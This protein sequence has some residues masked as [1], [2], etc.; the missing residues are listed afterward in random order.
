[1]PEARLLSVAAWLLLAGAAPPPLRPVWHTASPGVETSEV[2]VPVAGVPWRTRLVLARVDPARVTLRVV[3]ARRDDGRGAWS[4]DSAPPR[5]LVAF[6]AG[7]FSTYEPWGWIVQ[8]GREL[9]PP[10]SG[11]LA[12]AFVVDTAGTARIVPADSV[13]TVRAAGGV[14]QAVQSYPVLVADGVPPA[15][16]DR[17]DV[18]H[19]DARLALGVLGD[20]RV[21]VVLTRFEGLGESLDGVPLGPTVPEMAALMRELGCRAAMLLDGGI[22]SQLLLRDGRS[23]RRWRGY[24]RVPV[25]LVATAPAPAGSAP[26]LA[27]RR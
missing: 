14:A 15:Q 9:Q 12:A 1:V 3:G 7:Q 22:S 6:N 21:L 25:A 11:P 27:V 8:D 2:V 18:E 16:L 4:V 24:R 26:G 19:R 13:A 17:I 10:G 5:A 23:V 20:G